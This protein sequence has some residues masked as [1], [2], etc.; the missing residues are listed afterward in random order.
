MLALFLGLGIAGA[1]FL[2]HKSNAAHPPPPVGKTAPPP[3]APNP[4]AVA[5][6]DGTQY[7]AQGQPQPQGVSTPDAN[8]TGGDDGIEI[9]QGTPG[10]GENPGPATQVVQ[11]PNAGTVSLNPGDGAA[12]IG[13]PGTTLG[14]GDGTE[15]T[16]TPDPVLDL[17][18]MEVLDA[19]YGNSD[20][21]TKQDAANAYSSLAQ[22]SGLIF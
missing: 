4:T 16:P 12:A 11:D 1:I 5:Q 21:L 17:Q 8:A 18:P 13:G 19:V 9:D 10:D 2:S 14:A 15:P 3:Q 22:S 6:G 20:G 7:D